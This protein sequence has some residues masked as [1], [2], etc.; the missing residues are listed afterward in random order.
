M[1][2]IVQGVT[3]SWTRLSNFRIGLGL[4]RW[5][6]GKEPSSNA[7]HTVLIPRLGRPPGGE[8]GH[9]LQCSWPGKSHGQSSLVSCSQWGVA[10][11][12]LEHSRAPPSPSPH[13]FCK[14]L[15]TLIVFNTAPDCVPYQ[16]RQYSSCLP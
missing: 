6:S 12:S 1:D 9:P 10:K 13:W 2:C 5:L 8:N 7:G 4:P 15:M 3:K 16:A 14:W 11:S